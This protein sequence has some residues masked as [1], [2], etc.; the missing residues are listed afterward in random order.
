[1][2]NQLQK[3]YR[4]K[5]TPPTPPVTVTP[6]TVTKKINEN[7]DQL[8]I[9]NGKEYTYNIKTTLSKAIASFKKFEIT[10]SVDKDLTVI[11]ADIKNEAM[12][13]FFTVTVPEKVAGQGQIITRAINNFTAAAPFADQEVELI[14]TAKINDGIT[15][16]SIP[17]TTKVI[18]N[19]SNVVDVPDL[20]TPPTPPVTVTPPGEVPTVEKTINGS[21][22]EAVVEP[23]SNYTYNITATLPRDIATYKIFSIVDT[24]DVRLSL[25]EGV[26]PTIKGEAAKFFTVDV[27]GQKVIAKITDFKAG[28]LC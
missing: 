18:Y 6:P 19:N 20:E 2:I 14:I 13:S 21:L 10:D 7:R 4:I 8:A 9:E 16:A 26:K 22:T 12:R 5:T 3:V 27:S 17:N 28:S 15:R 23:E 25:A 24:L 1:M 11:K